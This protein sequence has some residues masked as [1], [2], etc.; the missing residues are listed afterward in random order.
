[1]NYPIWPQELQQLPLVDGFSSTGVTPT[2]RQQMESGLD[3]VTRIS[4]TTVRTNQYSIICD[5]TQAAIFWD[6]FNREANAG[7]DFVIM[8]M[9]TSNGILNH[10][11]RFSTYPNQVPDGIEWRISFSLETD[12]QHTNWS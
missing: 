12:E 5:K 9:S 8:P 1:M 3:R 10:V 4:S 11:C 2:K 6:F 7:A